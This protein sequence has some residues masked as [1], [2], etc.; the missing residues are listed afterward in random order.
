MY[1]LKNRRYYIHMVLRCKGI[2]FFV[3]EKSINHEFRLSNTLST[4]IIFLILFR[5]L[6]HI[7]NLCY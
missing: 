7:I 1:F 2:C 6:P 4:H 3:F 5:Y